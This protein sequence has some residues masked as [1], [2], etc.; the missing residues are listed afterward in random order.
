MN[1][2][3]GSVFLCH[4]DSLSR[5]LSQLEELGVDIRIVDTDQPDDQEPAD[6]PSQDAEEG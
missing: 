1:G 3:F 6:G 5:C 4:N 2:Q